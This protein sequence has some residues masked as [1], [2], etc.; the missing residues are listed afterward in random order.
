MKK[1]PA[2]AS[3]CFE[4]HFQVVPDPVYLS[5]RQGVDSRSASRLTP[6]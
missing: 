1:G 5:W 4:G 3:F 2:L 6:P